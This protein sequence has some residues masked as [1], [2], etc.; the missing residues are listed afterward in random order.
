MTISVVLPG[1]LRPLAGG[2]KTVELQPPGGTLQTLLD[3]LADA[4]PSLTRRIRDEQGALRRY[5]NIYIDGE[6]VRASGGLS[7][8][9]ADGAEV[10]ILPSVAGG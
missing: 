6:D 9:V 3:A 4:H 2:A 10:R 7:T 5:V 1:A 8:T